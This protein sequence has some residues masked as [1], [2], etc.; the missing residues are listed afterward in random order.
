MGSVCSRVESQPWAG[1]TSADGLR[2]PQ[3]NQWR[4]DE[5][6]LGQVWGGSSGDLHKVSKVLKESLTL[7]P[8]Y[9]GEWLGREETG[10]AKVS[11]LEL[12]DEG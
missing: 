6:S 12:Q 5:R 9:Q 1:S 10:K 8:F 11:T 2:E 4:E 3:W 7:S